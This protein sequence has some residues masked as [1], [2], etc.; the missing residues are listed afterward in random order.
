CTQPEVSPMSR[1]VHRSISP[2]H[3]DAVARGAARLRR[4]APLLM[5]A[6]AVSVTSGSAVAVKLFAILGPIGTLW[7]R[8]LLAALILA[9]F[10]RPSLRLPTRGQT[11]RLVAL[12]LA[13][14]ACNVSFYESLNRVPLSVAST[15][16]FLGPLAI[17][18]AGTRHFVDLAWVALAA[19]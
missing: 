10:L 13:L 7:I 19:A 9:A 14:A 17:A 16:E 5:V 2:E 11:L 1:E 15:V 8:N 4:A 12:G 18:L 3:G 6:V